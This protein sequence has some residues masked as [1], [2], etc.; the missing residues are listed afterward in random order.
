VTLSLHWHAFHY[1]RRCF[2]PWWRLLTSPGA[3]TLR[4]G[5]SGWSAPVLSPDYNASLN[6]SKFFMC[7]PPTIGNRGVMFAGRTCGRPSVV[8]QNS[9]R[10][11]RAVSLYLADVF[12][13]NFPQIFIMTLCVEI[14][15]KIFSVRVQRSRSYVCK[16]MNGIT[17]E[18]YIS[19]SLSCFNISVLKLA[20]I[21]GLAEILTFWACSLCPCTY[22]THRA[23]PFSFRTFHLPALST[24][25]PS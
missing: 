10:V 19:M 16:C 22:A 23:G 7:L 24:H 8:R 12:W 13:W 9:F 11:T 6:D 25:K 15:E 4:S 3:P 21:Q 20:P 1:Q 2:T 18:A 14:D 17:A 5:G